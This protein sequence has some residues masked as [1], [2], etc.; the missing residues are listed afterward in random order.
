MRSVE[1][2]VEAAAGLA[3]LVCDRVGALQAH[4]TLL[5]EV[6]PEARDATRAIITV[7][8]DAGL[9]KCYSGGNAVPLP[10][11]THLRFL[12]AGADA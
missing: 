1:A 6:A 2:W 3:M 9:V 7:L 8:Y 5:R 11:A 10:H 4:D 12:D